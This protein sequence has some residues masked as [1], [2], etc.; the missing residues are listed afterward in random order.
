MQKHLKPLIRL[1]C[2]GA[3]LCMAS[4]ACGQWTEKAIHVFD[5][6]GLDPQG[7]RGGVIQGQ[8]GALYGTSYVVVS[9]AW[10][11][12]FKLNTDGTGLTLLRIF[13]YG[14][15]EGFQP[16]T[17]LLQG[18]D[19][20]LYGTT[21]F[22]TTTDGASTGGSIFKLN[23]NGG[24][25]AVLYH[26]AAAYDDST[27][28]Y[29]P[30]L[31]G[32]DGALYLTTEYAG[33]NSAG[34][35]F[36]LNTDGTG[37]TL[38]HNFGAFTGDGQNPAAG[39]VQG[40]DGFLY[41]TTQ[42]GGSNSFGTAYKV[43]TNGSGYTLLHHFGA[44]TDGANPAARLVQSRDGA[45][46]GTTRSGGTNLGAY[47]STMGTVFKL[48]TDGSGYAVL[49]NF[50]SAGPWALGAYSELVEGGEGALYGTS[51][52]GGTTGGGTVFKLDPDGSGYSV[53]YTFDQPT[54]YALPPPGVAPGGDGA[55]YGTTYNDG[56]GAGTVFRLTMA[57]SRF[58][59][60]TLSPDKSIQLSLTGAS[61]FTYRID[62]STD[63]LSWVTLTN[64]L[65]STGTIQFTDPQA[66]DFQ[67]RF[68]RAVWVP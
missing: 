6:N 55:W 30:L 23:T 21:G 28:G 36:K 34:T 47:G 57:P 44:G 22:G 45:L 59:S 2:A 58:T 11:S 64:V 66:P 33:S 53:L 26:F 9:N 14:D 10:G 38:L 27:Y 4:S 24:D 49:Y 25:F 50:T 39:L 56:L 68:Y 51:L 62:A 29:S 67:Q 43:N 61:N 13:N 42:A 8:D 32:F 5:T 35:V 1:A 7:P 41:G 15:A 31:Q 63:L 20:M 48:G 19:G 46:Y 18:S 52:S 16:C 60:V 12:V 54:S 40:R 65:N 17:G 37:Y 3:A